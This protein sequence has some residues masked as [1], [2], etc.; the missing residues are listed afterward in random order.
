MTEVSQ[1]NV[2][3]IPEIGHALAKLK[4]LHSLATN[5]DFV[6][7]EAKLTKGE[8]EALIFHVQSTIG[9]FQMPDVPM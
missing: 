3:S 4:Q 5:G 6:V 9:N 7:S 8:L 1:N 2:H